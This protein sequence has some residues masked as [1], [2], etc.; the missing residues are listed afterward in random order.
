MK[1]KTQPKNWG[2][3]IKH[4]WNFFSGILFLVKGTTKGI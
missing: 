3:Y 1:K 2:G 4:L